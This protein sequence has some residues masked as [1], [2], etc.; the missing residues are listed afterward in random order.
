MEN[1]SIN[2]ALKKYLDDKFE[3]IEKKFNDL[4]YNVNSIHLKYYNENK[5]KVSQII[6]DRNGPNGRI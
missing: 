5:R 6:L 2:K 1:V 4:E 3:N